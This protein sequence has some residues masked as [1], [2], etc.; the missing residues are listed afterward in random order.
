MESDLTGGGVPDGEELRKEG[1]RAGDAA[2]VAAELDEEEYAKARE[3]TD[4]G[5]VEKVLDVAVPC[6]V[7]EGGR[8]QRRRDCRHS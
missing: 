8:R 3:G 2:V 7:V 5:D 1:E 4:G 6:E